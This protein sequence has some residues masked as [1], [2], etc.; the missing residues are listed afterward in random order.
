MISIRSQE[1]Y[2]SIPKPKDISFELV[3]IITIFEK[4]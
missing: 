4:D 3:E 1:K 2:Y